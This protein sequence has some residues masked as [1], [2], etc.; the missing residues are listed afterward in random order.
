MSK[1]ASK[2]NLMTRTGALMVLVLVAVFFGQASAVKMTSTIQE[3][4]Y[5]FEMKG[6]SDEAI[7]LLEKVAKEGDSDDIESANFYLGK[8]FELADNNELANKYYNQSLSTTQKTDLAY[9]L[10]AR[11]AATNSTPERLLKRIISLRSPIKKIF[12]GPEANI[13]FENGTLGKIE[14][15][16]LKTFS[17]NIPEEAIVFDISKQGLWSQNATRDTLFFDAFNQQTPQKSYAISNI[18]NI[19]VFNDDA[20]VQNETDIYIINKKGIVSQTKNKYSGCQVHNQKYGNEYYIFNCPDNA[21]HFISMVNATE[22]FSIAQYDAIQHVYI[23][24][25]SI[26]LAAGGN[27]LRYDPKITSIPTWKI[28]IGNIDSM[29][30]FGNKIAILEA[31]GKITLVGMNSGKTFA[32]AYSDASTIVPLAQGTLGLFS[33]EGALTTVDTLLH[34]LWNF[35]FAKPL[36]QAP[37]LA[38]DRIYLYFGDSR[39]FS[40]SAHYYGQRELYSNML[41]HRAA[42]FSEIGR[43]KE[44]PQLLDSLIKQEP[45]NAE[46]WFFKALYL[47]RTNAPEK[48][49]KRT[50][51]EAV[52]LSIS[53]PQ[54][55]HL[56][57]GHYSKVIGA[58]F[59]NLMNISPK[60]IYPQ[61]FGT[62]KN[63]FTVDPAAERLLCINAETGEQRW[64]KSIGKTSDAPV[65]ESRENLLAM[66]SGY[67]I[68]F[69]DLNKDLAKTTL[70]LPGKAFNI[71]IDDEAIYVTTWNGFLLKINK[72][73]NQLLWSRKI[74]SIP[75]YMAK[76][77]NL[78]L[79]NLDGEMLA[80]DDATG[81]NLEGSSRRIQTNVTQL[82]SVD[83]ILIIATNTNKLCLFNEKRNDQPPTQILM[84]SPIVSLQAFKFQ[85]RSLILVTL[86]DQSILLYSSLGTP[87]WKFQGKNSIFSKPLLYE[88]A[89]WIDQGSEV[90]AISLKE[91]KIQ[92]RFNTPG[93]AGTPFILN[94]TLFSASP[95]RLL[96]GF[97]L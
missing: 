22:A 58:K 67:Q 26:F 34:P 59:V 16:S 56:I 33:N 39:L 47:E 74:F 87:L 64:S 54:A 36:V 18:S 65:I 89:L 31:T 8:I 62:R 70:Q 82:A 3:A 46:A 83:S 63:L 44:M 17:I 52:R 45:G 6:N 25:N 19:T 40:I 85:E 41:A 68:N 38:E 13:L 49:R 30:P 86:S 20:V 7:R 2:G 15:D 51:S 73:D 90:V 12:D 14:G 53:N 76:N 37:L 61:F 96:Y 84:E 94:N 77:I 27:L 88:D 29:I 23:H 72:A 66:S 93:G 10:A 43:W 80:I 50:W 71:N 48:E 57:L 81:Q 9:W 24:N 11:D 35:N 91:G 79:C 21:L 55:T 69:Y 75:F 28:S 60:T 78:Q 92:K 95:K 42:K 4:I 97:S 5:L 1:V 32:S